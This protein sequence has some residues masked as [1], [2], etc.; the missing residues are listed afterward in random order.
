MR[1]KATRAVKR[2]VGDAVED[3]AEKEARKQVSKAEAHY[4]KEYDET[5]K[6]AMKNAKAKSIAGKMITDFK[7]FQ[8]SW[9]KD[10]DK[11]EQ[12]VYHFLIATYNYCKNPKIGEPMATIIL[13]KKHNVKDTS[14]PSNLKLG[15]TNKRLLEHMR[16]DLNIA[17]SYL[18]A[19]YTEDYKFN[20]KKPTM[21]LLAVEEDE[22]YANVVIQS[23]GKDLPTPVALAKNNSGQWKITEFSSIATGC[24]KPASVEGDF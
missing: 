3:A 21:S 4:K 18:G 2:A 15:P 1:R 17:K 11:P 13:S 24:R 22:K 6:K 8:K 16:E 23:G 10:A 5:V 9:E 14:S 7:E 20:E 12:S 19:K